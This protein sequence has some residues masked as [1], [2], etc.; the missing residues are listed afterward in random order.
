MWKILCV[1]ILFV[2]LTNTAKIGKIIGPMSDEA[3][4]WPMFGTYYTNKYAKLAREIV[5]NASE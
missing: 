5:H 4:A 2:Q 3:D 1:G